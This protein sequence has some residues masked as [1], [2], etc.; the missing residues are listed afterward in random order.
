MLTR[1]W[2]TEWYPGPDITI[3]WKD[4]YKESGQ[5]TWGNAVGPNILRDLYNWISEQGLSQESHHEIFNLGKSDY[6]TS[7]PGWSLHSIRS[8]DLDLSCLL[9]CLLSSQIKIE[10]H[11]SLSVPGLGW[12][13]PAPD[14]SA[15]YEDH[16]DHV[17]GWG[18]LRDLTRWTG[19]GV[20][21][22]ELRGNGQI[23][24]RTLSRHLLANIAAWA[25]AGAG[26]HLSVVWW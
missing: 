13:G 23:N 14:I 6:L 16:D 15:C 18:F 20:R 12:T 25:G 17:V 7:W 11:S 5:A 21:S 9:S 4:S 26:R 2:G 19:R 1:H 8:P 3:V 10:F 24:L 22:G